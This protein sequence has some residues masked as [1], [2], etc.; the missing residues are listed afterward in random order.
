VIGLGAFLYFTDYAAEGT[1]TAKGRDAEGDYVV[2]RPTIFPR[3]IAQHLDANAAQF[4]CEGYSV[5]YRLQTQHYQVKD[6]Q[7]RLVYDSEEGLTDLF[8]PTRC[9]LL[10]A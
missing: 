4:V 2:I 5:T 9:A 7:G 1:I 10:G 8:S 3:E 6:A